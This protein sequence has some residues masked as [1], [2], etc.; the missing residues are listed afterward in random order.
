MPLL[1]LPTACGAAAASASAPGPFLLSRPPPS[2]LRASHVLFAFPRL[3]KYGRRSREPVPTTLDDDDEEE[4]DEDDDDDME[5]AVDEDIFLKNRPKPAGFGVG[6]TYTTDVEEQLLREM[7][8]GGAGR[9]SKSA[10]PKSSKTNGSAT[11]TAADCSNDGVHV[12]IWNLPKKKNIHKDLNLAFKGFPGLVTINPANSGTKK[13]RDPICKGFAFVKL[14]SVD[15]ATRFVELYSRKAVSF[16]K[17][18]KPIKC[19]IVEGHISTDPSG[20]ASSSQ[21]PGSNPQ[22]LV[23]VR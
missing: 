19:C 6:K 10:P 13:T 20:P 11:E 22:R 15:A 18:E 12:R 16:G 1:Q 5:E 8:I 2:R 3:R 17:V 23:A 14:E 7:G 4:A 9:K 21:P